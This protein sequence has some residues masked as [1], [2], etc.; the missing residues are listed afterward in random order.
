M[1][2]LT[3][4]TI[5]EV[6]VAM[7]ITAVVVSLSFAGLRLVQLQFAQYQRQQTIVADYRRCLTLLKH[8]VYHSTYVVYTPEHLQCY[9]IPDTIYYQ[10]RENHVIRQY[11]LQHRDTF[12]V[13]IAIHNGYFQ[14]L[15]RTGLVDELEIH[16]GLTDFTKHLRHRKVY[17]AADLIRWEDE[18]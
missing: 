1:K 5:I 2:Q 6:M 11:G 16:V 3:A 13:N 10:F 15:S 9:N 17:S 4:F 12:P 14:G 8:D 18:Y 7:A